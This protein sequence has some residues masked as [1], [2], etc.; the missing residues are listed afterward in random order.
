VK[1]SL[2]CCACRKLNVSP[3]PE[4]EPRAWNRGVYRGIQ[5]E[6][7]S[8]LRWFEIFFSQSSYSEKF[9]RVQKTFRNSGIRI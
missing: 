9:V 2:F 1:H 3:A 4:A 5:L 6:F 8:A 7:V